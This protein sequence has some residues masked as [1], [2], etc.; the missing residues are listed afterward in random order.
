MRNIVRRAALGLPGF[1]LA[2]CIGIAHISVSVPPLTINALSTNSIDIDVLCPNFYGEPRTFLALVA[3]SL[4]PDALHY[5]WKRI[6]LS[7]A[8][9]GR[10]ACRNE[11]RYIGFPAVPFVPTAPSSRAAKGRRLFVHVD[12]ENIVYRIASI[13]NSARVEGIYL[14]AA[15][16][17][18]PP[19]LNEPEPR[20]STPA[21]YER[22]RVTD[23]YYW[24]RKWQRSD[25]IAITDV[26]VDGD[27]AV[28]S[29]GMSIGMT[30]NHPLERAGSLAPAN[31]EAA[32]AGRSAPSR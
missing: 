10:A 29:I 28:L 16:K 19:E 20:V 3:G 8:S 25:R 22:I 5:D 24:S 30:A 17:D 13:R 12:K 2:G 32:N 26:E 14:E 31:A 27:G 4:E 21:W 6:H 23:E 11:R 1:L 7:P 18:F 9:S 15:R